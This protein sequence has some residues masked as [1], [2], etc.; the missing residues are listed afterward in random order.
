MQFFQKTFGGLL[1]IVLLMVALIYFRAPQIVTSPNNWL[2]GDTYDGFRSYAAM[3]YHIRHD[4]TYHHYEGMHY[5]YGDKT[6][7]TD[8]LPL[9][10]NSLKF[11]SQYF[12]DLSV[13]SAGALN[14][15]LLSSIVLCAVFLFLSFRKMELPVW[16]A[17]PVSIGITML[18]PQLFRLEAHY[19]LVAPFVVPMI[20]WLSLVFHRKKSVI[21]SLLIGTVLFLVAQIH[22]YLF[23]IAAAFVLALLF[24]K[25]MFAFSRKAFIINGLHLFLQ[26]FLPLILLQWFLQDNLDDRPTRP[27]GFFTYK[28][29]WESVFLPVD[30]QLGRWIDEYVHKIPWFGREGV[31]YIGLVSVLFFI[32]EGIQ[33]GL[34]RLFGNTYRSI[35]EEKHRF[36]LK[37][38]FWA[39][40][41]ALLFSFAFPFVLPGFEKIPEKLGI[42]AQFRSPGRFAWCFFYVFNI[43]AFYALFFQIKKLKKTSLQ[44]MFFIL[45]IGACLVEGIISAKDKVK[46]DLQPV[47]AMRT[48]FRLQDN[49]WLKAINLN[50][51][52]AILNIPYFHIGSENIWVSPSNKEVH[53]SM[54]LAAQT[55]LPIH[56]SF[57]GRTSVGQVIDQM[58]LM[59][60]PY[61]RPEVLNHYKK[62]KN[63]LVFVHL[64]AYNNI[65][66]R[67]KHFLKG[68]D[69]LYADEHIQVYHLSPE[70]LENRIAEKNNQ[71]VQDFTE[72]DSSS[73]FKHDN[74][75]TNDSLP[76]VFYQNFDQLQS[77][78]IYRGSGAL[79]CP[80]FP[81]QTIYDG[82]LP[83]QSSGEWY[84]LSI[85]VYMDGDLHPKTRMSIE[86]YQTGSPY[87]LD[88][89]EYELNKY[90]WAVEK[91]WVLCE[92][93]FKLWRPD[94]RICIKIFN[95]DKNDESIFVDE[96]LIRPKASD[97]YKIS[98]KELMYNNRWWARK[99]Q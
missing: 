13:Y 87:I 71:V 40:F 26:V 53:R 14:I 73:L 33:K 99:L 78:K 97:F 32:K 55:G 90:F 48:G 63:L 52:Q 69:L 56:S 88:K 41:V 17:V 77:E 96:L 39:A 27:F 89:K 50:E 45:I 23:A 93:P 65:K 59:G 35:P 22:F 68:L 20:F 79:Q 38:S 12:G 44:V 43:I 54:W 37:S 24:F 9:L 36:F 72:A 64:P 92:F 31:A 91:G 58:Q 19:G 30:F 49:A 18:S 70:T 6:A 84:D 57:M 83:F 61:R 74:Y 47:P 76:K 29:I 7:F 75:L 5:P 11:L 85:W 67:Y 98:D 42:I 16:Y 46:L 28:A 81:A 10:S 51:Y 82:H 1:V 66:S 94:S 80:G 62:D 15:F 34:N 21:I 2:T 95:A 60:E 3:V 4:S 8:N 25:S 86:E